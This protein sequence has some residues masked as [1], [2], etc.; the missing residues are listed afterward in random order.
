ME[1]NQ[2]AEARQR[3]APL[4]QEALQNHQVNPANLGGTATFLSQMLGVIIGT[5]FPPEELENGIQFIRRS[6]EYGVQHGMPES[7]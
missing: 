3:L 7:K 6:I 4:L 1:M 5:I 2:E